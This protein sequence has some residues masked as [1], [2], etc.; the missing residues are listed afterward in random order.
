MLIAL[1][2]K[3][4][5]QVKILNKITMMIP[6]ELDKTEWLLSL[7]LRMTQM[8]GFQDT[9]SMKTKILELW[10]RQKTL[11]CCLDSNWIRISN[12]VSTRDKNL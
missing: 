5:S 11:N 2:N 10:K 3:I 12:L 7:C 6:R 9:M 8:L 4:T 1:A